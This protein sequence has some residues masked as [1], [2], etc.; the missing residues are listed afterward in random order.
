MAATLSKT[1]RMCQLR[2]VVLWI[3]V[4]VVAIT[5]LIACLFYSNLTRTL[6]VLYIIYINLDNSY[7]KA[8]SGSSWIRNLDF[9]KTK[10]A[11]YPASLHKTAELPTDRPYIFGYHPHGVI[12]VGC[13][14]SF[15]TEALGVSKKFPGIKIHPATLHMNFL[16]PGFREMLLS[17]G[18]VGCG[19]KSLT[20]CLRK[21]E[22]VVLVVGGAQEAMD[23]IP[24]TNTL[25]IKKRFGF[26]KLALENGAGLVPVFGFGEND[27]WDQVNNREGTLVRRFQELVKRIIGASPLLVIG[28]FGVIPFR[29]QVNIVVGAPILCPKVDKPTDEQVQKYHALYVDALERLYH[30]HKDRLLPDR[31]CDLV[32]S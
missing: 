30:D 6:A 12:C 9:W 25:T 26:I 29:K 2:N 21:N 14:M 20:Y 10:A 13:A 4:P 27:L 19:K 24:G 22:S 8:N 16:I 18:Y 32:I 7:A 28:R 5:L 15:G 17:G 3:S 1:E 23:A 31:T 11:Y